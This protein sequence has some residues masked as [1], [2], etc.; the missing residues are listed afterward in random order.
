MNFVT[1]FNHLVIDFLN[2]WIIQLEQLWWCVGLV[3]GIT[4]TLFW[5]NRQSKAGRLFA[6]MAMLALIFQ[7]GFYFA[8]PHLAF[9]YANA[10]FHLQ[11][12]HLWGFG[13]G[14][15]AGLA[16]VI[17]LIRYTSPY[18]EVIKHRLTKAN[19]TERNRKTDIRQIG[20]HLP[21]S[22]S[23]YDPTKYCND[24]KGMF[25]G[26]NEQR[27]PVYIPWQQWRKSHVD[28]IGT[29]GSGKGVAAGVLLSQALASGECVVVVDPK[30]DEWLPYVMREAA[31]Q[32][33]VPYVYIDLQSEQPQWNP[34]QHKNANE[35]EEL[36]SA[37]FSLGEKGT[38]ADFY[39]LDDRR[40]ARIFANL[41]N[42]QDYSLIETLQLLIQ[43]QPDIAEAGKKFVSDLEEIGLVNA[44]NTRAGVDLG[45]LIKQGA[46]IYM[47]GSMRNPRILKLQR[48]FVLSV[49]QHIE[50]R[51]RE[52]VN[53]QKARHACLFL[54]EFKYLISRPTLEALGA[55]RDKG[56]HVMIAHQSLGD[57]RDCP[58]DLDPES[59]VASV[60]EN[61]AIK[62]AYQ[63]KDPD[64]ALWL[65]RMSGTILV[66]DEIRQVKTNAGL[67]EARDGGRTLRQAERPLVDTNM[68]HALPERCAVLYG[69]GL[70]QFFF[71][72]PIRVTKSRWAITPVSIPGAEPKLEK[73]SPAN[74]SLTTAQSLLDVD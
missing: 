12:Y 63:V 46:V 1:R 72:S 62:M 44:V 42:R 9:Y 21:D 27:K 5:L 16:M 30:N 47:R 58:A 23:T 56:A 41:A 69:A 60:N 18:I 33:N 36:L 65:A 71:T 4:A 45:S 13:I 66:D 39:R 31:R 7:P 20:V 52:L 70:A 59:V 54:D 10:V 2:A 28:V 19:S 53:G 37:G 6:S 61:C 57:L 15:F 74:P 67:T 38:D 17:L 11:T 35:I 22:Q 24:K 64:T 25:F 3:F 29:T 55:I 73:P 68:L 14:S 50:V 43:H 48:I 32:A 34:L 8:I 51:P 40:A 26:L 49:M